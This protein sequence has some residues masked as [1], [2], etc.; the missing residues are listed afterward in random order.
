MLGISAIAY[1]VGSDALLEPQ[2]IPS[3]HTMTEAAASMR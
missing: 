2:A 3:P 1:R